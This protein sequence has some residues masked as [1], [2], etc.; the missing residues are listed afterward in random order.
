M[1]DSSNKEQLAVAYIR[2]EVQVPESLRLL[3]ERYRKYERIRGE[4]V[5]FPK[6]EDDDANKIYDVLV[7]MA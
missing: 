4:C 2:G 3:V 5:S 6:S 7:V 1:T